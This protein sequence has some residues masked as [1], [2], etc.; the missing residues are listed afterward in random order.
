[1]VLDLAYSHRTS[2]QKWRIVSLCAFGN[3]NKDFVCVF[4]SYGFLS[5]L[6]ANLD[7]WHVSLW[8]MTLVYELKQVSSQDLLILRS[9]VKI[10]WVN[11]HIS[12]PNTLI[13]G[14]QNPPFWVVWWLDVPITS[15]LAYYRFNRWRW[16]LKAS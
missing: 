7:T 15:M 6:S 5:G 12:V 14:T 3:C 11:F 13:S 2:L 10:L 1:M 4:W 8:I 16:Y 9:R